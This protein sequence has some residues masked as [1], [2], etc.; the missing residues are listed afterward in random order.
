MEA[1]PNHNFL[2][3]LET[4]GANTSIRPW[5]WITWLFVGPI[6]RNL[7]FQWYIFIATRTL[8][9]TQGLLTQLVFEHSLR[10]SLK[11][12]VTNE[13]IENDNLTV[14]GTQDSESVTEGTSVD[15]NSL[16]REIASQSSQAVTPISRD[17]SSDS[18]ST[19]NGPIKV[20]DSSTRTL[21]SDPDTKSA[22][23]DKEAQNLIGKINNLVTTDISNIIEARDF[24]FISTLQFFSS[25]SGLFSDNPASFLSPTRISSVHHLLI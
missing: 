22:T 24:L 17:S 11:A 20:M 14:I 12:E 4:G 3:Y 23:K 7:C 15:S 8:V 6:V 10:I 25:G 5:F 21:K 13:K 1:F 9:R 16:T 19:S 2:S 18:Q